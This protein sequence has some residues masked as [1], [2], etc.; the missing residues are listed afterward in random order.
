[1][2]PLQGENEEQQDG[3]AKK[4]GSSENPS[5]AEG[6]TEAQKSE[7]LDA[8][9]EKWGELL[10]RLEDTDDLRKNR[11]ESFEGLLKNRDVSNSYVHR[12][13]QYEDIIVKD[14]FPSL[15]GIEKKFEDIIEKAPDN[16]NEYLERNR[17][18]EDY[19]RLKKGE[20]PANRRRAEI[21]K[22]G[23]LERQPLSFPKANREKY[24]DKILPAPKE[25]QMRDF[26][27]N[28][29]Q[30]DPDKGDLPEAMR[31]LY[32]ENLQRLAYIFAEDPTYFIVDYY[33]ENLN[34]EDFLMH[35]LN[36]VSKHNNTKL[37]AEILF[38]LENIYEIQQRALGYFFQFDSLYPG[39]DEK[40]KQELRVETLSRVRERYKKILKEKKL[41]DPARLDNLYFERRLQ[42]MNYL[43]N[44]SPNGYRR[45]DALFEKG[46]ILW[47]KA[48][49]TGKPAD[50]NAAVQ[51]WESISGGADENEFLM[52]KTWETLLPLVRQYK[53]NSQNQSL[54]FSIRR[55][56]DDRLQESLIKKR[57]REN[58]LLW[59][60][61]EAESQQP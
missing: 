42:V 3:S 32:Y 40:Q 16:L 30:Y 50:F 20:L 49:K 33:Q 28:Y 53:S 54:Q 18:I 55:T 57:I 14:V 52:K 48:E 36:L 23:E 8:D 5:E 59:K 29:G 22:E 56:L 37:M 12:P 9:P 1:M 47:E 6:L 27:Q 21:K 31:D 61:T 4:S 15:N 25:S 44:N 39:L 38:A 60:D 41:S 17:I 19:R 51:V 11:T 35:S 46:R 43:L 45:E 34:K 2:Q 7:M 26:L 58:R 10:N 13:R 24:L